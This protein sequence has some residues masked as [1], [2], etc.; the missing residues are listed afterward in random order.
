M[1]G[2]LS[3]YIKKMTI[4]DVNNFAISKN[5]SLTGEELEFVYVFI[6]KNWETILS[7]PKM[8]KLDRYKDKFTEDNFIKIN[9]LFMEYYQK[10]NI[11]LR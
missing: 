6:K 4:E 10:Y 3:R 1:F 2:I 9:K 5:I 7:N 11:Y 8:L